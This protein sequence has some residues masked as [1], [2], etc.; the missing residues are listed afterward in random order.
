MSRA[1][2]S[3]LMLDVPRMNVDPKSKYGITRRFDDPRIIEF[4]PRPRRS[5]RT[6]APIVDPLRRFEIEED[7]LR[8]QQNLAAA[9]V[10]LV[11][12]AAGLPPATGDRDDP[13]P[14]FDA[15]ALTFCSAPLRFPAARN[16]CATPATPLML[17][18]SFETASRFKRRPLAGPEIIGLILGQLEIIRPQR[19]EDI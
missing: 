3:R 9:I 7:R 1:C 4:K 6:E 16:S 13:L 8:M 11:L 12:L 15:P 18:A 5:K 2:V 19:R 17:N 14:S 10:L